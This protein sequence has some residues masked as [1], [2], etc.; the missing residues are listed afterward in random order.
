MG[1][2]GLA[3]PGTEVTFPMVFA[4]L[5]VSLVILCS[6]ADLEVGLETIQLLCL[7]FIL[8]VGLTG[9]I[10]LLYYLGRYRPSFSWPSDKTKS[11]KIRISFLWLFVF[12]VTV[13]EIALVII[14]VECWLVTYSKLEI[15]ELIFRIS[16]IGF[17]ISQV[18]IF[19]VC[20]VRR[21]TYGGGKF[22][23]VAVRAIIFTN[24]T[25][26]L[27]ITVND[28]SGLYF[29]VNYN[30]T[31][32]STQTQEP[33]TTCVYDSSVYP[34]Y[35]K[36][37]QYTMPM[38]LEFYILASNSFVLLLSENDNGNFWGRRSFNILPSLSKNVKFENTEKLSKIY[39]IAGIVNVTL[40]ITI[41][42][43]LLLLHGKYLRCSCSKI[44]LIENVIN[45]LQGIISIMAIINTVIGFHHLFNIE[46]TLPPNRRLFCRRDTILVI[47]MT[48]IVA[49]NVID[50][51]DFVSTAGTQPTY[52]IA[53]YLCANIGVIVEAFYQ[54]LLVHKT[55]SIL[56]SVEQI[57][58]KRDMISLRY[59]LLNVSLY[60]LTMWVIHS[61]FSL[62]IG[63]PIILGSILWNIVRRILFPFSTYFLFQSSF[64][65]YNLYQRTNT[66]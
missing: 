24:I 10:Y 50:S 66:T 60:S 54:T 22:S 34:I 63:T 56:Q 59:V 61:F 2:P 38:Y 41:L 13:G 3:G 19:M 42:I 39:K 8:C 14:N 47:C 7:T 16:I 30:N 36:M 45:A 27:S 28:V 35:M 52:S 57:D 37:L 15:G 31:N 5:G 65:L 11:W 43:T 51:F 44:S 18:V 46:K 33:G 1:G 12:G 29:G 26:W 4:V 40:D 6:Q 48:A 21:V 62:H 9:S 49:F 17:V 55:K 53:V 58:Y 23:M 32:Q 20:T 64:E 25:F